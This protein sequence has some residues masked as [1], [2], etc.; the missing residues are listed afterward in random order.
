MKICLIRERKQPADTRVALTP[1]IAASFQK[2][3][4]QIEILVERSPERVFSDADYEAHGLTLTDDPSQCDV[5]LGIKEV[6]VDDL[7]PGKTYMYF[8]HTIKEQPYNQKL[9]KAMAEKGIT[10]IDYECLSWPKGGRILGFGRWAGI[11]GAYNALLTW[12]TKFGT[13][14]LKPA[15][16]C[17]D[18]AEL[19]QELKKIS[20]SNIKIALTGE[21]RVAGGATEILEYLGLKEISPEDLDKEF[22]EPV[23]CIFKNHH[24]YRRKDGKDWDTAHFYTHHDEYEGVF[25][26]YLNEI[27]LLINGF[28][29]EDDLP[30]LF[31][32]KETAGHDFNIRVIADITCDVE[33]SVPITMRA[34]SIE[35]P[36]FGW[37]PETMKTTPPYL[38]NTID[39]MAVTNLPTEMPASASEEFGSDLTKYILPLFIEDPEGILKHA[40]LLENG[41]LTEDYDYLKDYLEG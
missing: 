20:L 37:D 38:E 4:P 25:H 15:H 36:T 40:T 13:F 19:K 27:D 16:K 18:Y 1:E 12:G 41:K 32:K 2:E 14:E 29:W 17:R 9:F 28:Y 31:T 24:I 7:I 21:G 23:F 5:L 30:P 33:G 8:S 34:T 39:V 6:P 3:Y 35:D 11:V 22:E 26:Y 10:M